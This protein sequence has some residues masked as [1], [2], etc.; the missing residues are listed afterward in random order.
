[1][2]STVAKKIV[3]GVKLNKNLIDKFG[4]SLRFTGLP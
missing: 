3:G 2:Q 1:M 4:L